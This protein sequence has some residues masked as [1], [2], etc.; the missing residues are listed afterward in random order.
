MGVGTPER[1]KRTVEGLPLARRGLLH[2]CRSEKLVLLEEDGPARV[3]TIPPHHHP[4]APS[5]RHSSRLS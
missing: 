3:S 5:Q 4:P 1:R 2:A